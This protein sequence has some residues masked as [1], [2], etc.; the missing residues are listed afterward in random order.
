MFVRGEV[1]NI[2][3]LAL[4]LFVN[5]GGGFELTMTG[6]RALRSVEVDFLRH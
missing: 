5:Y 4:E 6:S 3:F 1:R 2:A